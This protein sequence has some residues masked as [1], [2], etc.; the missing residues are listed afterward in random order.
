MFFK[1]ILLK[2]KINFSMVTT[3]MAINILLFV[4]SFFLTQ[5]YD[6]NI[7]L[8][9]LGAEFLPDILSGE[10]WRLVTPSFLHAGIFHLLLNMW[11]LYNLGNAIETFYGNRKVLIVYVLTGITGSIVSVAFTLFQIYN[12]QWTGGFPISVGA[13]ASIFGFVGLLIGNKFKKNTYSISIDNYIN[14]SQL[15]FFV[16]INIV[17]GLGVNFLGTSFAINNFAH[18]G[19]FIGGVLLGLVLDLV[20]TTYQ[21]RRKKFIEAALFYLVLIIVPLSFIAQLIYIV[22]SV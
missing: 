7:A 18:I 14:T 6:P 8:R 5:V 10:V 16:I 21:S 1:Q 12:S 22:L 3:L 11:A 20:N 15:W 17:F 4:V 2:I 13:S 19:G 9:L